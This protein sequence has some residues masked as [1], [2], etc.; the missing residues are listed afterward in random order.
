[1]P[2]ENSFS[3][4]GR[5]LTPEPEEE[6]PIS[7]ASASYPLPPDASHK[8]NTE[9]SR[10]KTQSRKS[11]HSRKSG[12]ALPSSTV[13]PIDRFRAAVRKVMAMRHGTSLLSNVGGIGAEPGIDPRRPAAHAAYS[14]IK[15]KCQIEIMD[16]SAIRSTTRTMDNAQ[17]IEF[18]DMDSPDLPQRDPWVKVR[19]INIGGISWDV[20]K[21][22]SIKYS[23]LLP[24]GAWLFKLE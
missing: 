16:Y 14:H 7:P 21:A 24:L 23:T 10:I 13:P 12:A 15:E 5:S 11:L 9:L 8:E 18:M 1:M 17:F 22:L 4:E 20:I 3:D 19:W 2:R 6:L